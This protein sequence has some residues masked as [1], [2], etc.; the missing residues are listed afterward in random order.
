[1]GFFIAC[2]WTFERGWPVYQVGRRIFKPRSEHS[3]E[4]HIYACSMCRFLIARLLAQLEEVAFVA[5]LDGSECPGFAAVRVSAEVFMKQDARS[6]T[7]LTVK[8]VMRELNLGRTKVYELI[9]T[10]GLPVVRFGRA[11]RVPMA[12]LQQWI[13][14]REEQ[15][16]S[17]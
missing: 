10:E 8:D 16:L 15:C 4:L 6:A 2:Y 12:S 17:A 13:S 3:F 9:K 11:V 7:L 5:A 1:M 14:E